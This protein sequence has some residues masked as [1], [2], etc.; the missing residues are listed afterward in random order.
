MDKQFLVER[1]NVIRDHQIKTLDTQQNK[2]YYRCYF[3][4]LV[5]KLIV[6]PYI[7][8]DSCTDILLTQADRFEIQEFKYTKNNFFSSSRNMLGLACRNVKDVISS[9]R[10]WEGV[11]DVYSVPK[12]YGFEDDQ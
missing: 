9:M 2:V 4:K 11:H 8:W 10:R 6:S 7:G 3:N 5:S 1:M 12:M